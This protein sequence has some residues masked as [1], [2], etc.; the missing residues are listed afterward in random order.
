[1]QS[2]S[3]SMMAALVATIILSVLMLMK[4]A[5]GIMPELNLP[6]MMADAMGSPDAPLLGW[7]AHIMIGVVV[8]GAI[9]A[10]LSTAFPGAGN[11]GQGVLS[12]IIGWLVMM[13]LVMPMLGAGLFGVDYGFM[14]PIVMLM[15]HLV[16]G[17]VLGWAYARMGTHEHEDVDANFV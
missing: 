9:M 7:T 5:F 12:G 17:G 2:L 13:V 8:Y 16:F 10:A 15:L 6:Q 11:V 1:M 3:R 4:G 14:S